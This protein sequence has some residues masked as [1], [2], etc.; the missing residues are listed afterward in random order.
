LGSGTPGQQYPIVNRDAIPALPAAGLFA[1][2]AWPGSAL[3]EF[4]C[5]GRSVWQVPGSAKHLT[6]YA[7]VNVKVCHHEVGKHIVASKMP[8]GERSFYMHDPFGNPI[9]LVNDRTLFLGSGGWV[10]S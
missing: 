4:Q 7:E 5:E 6:V 1:L 3:F 9:C 8:W 2:G 10:V